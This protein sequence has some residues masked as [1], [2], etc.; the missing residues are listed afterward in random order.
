MGDM[1]GFKECQKRFGFSK[2]LRE[3]ENKT[4]PNTDEIIDINDIDRYVKTKEEDSNFASSSEVNRELSEFYHCL[5]GISGCHEL[6][7]TDTQ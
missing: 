3:I 2:K 6:I 1:I 4:P 7:E 5:G